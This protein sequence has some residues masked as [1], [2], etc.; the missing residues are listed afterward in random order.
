MRDK[1]VRGDGGGDQCDFASAKV[2]AR[3]VKGAGER[4]ESM[5]LMLLWLFSLLTG[6]LACRAPP[7]GFRL[8][9]GTVGTE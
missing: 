7:T 5:L 9:V 2:G 4:G 1:L 3:C 8:T 6:T